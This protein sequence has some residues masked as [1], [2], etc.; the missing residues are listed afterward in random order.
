VLLYSS[1]GREVSV[2]TIG[3]GDILGEISILDGEPRS[4]SVVA[5]SDVVVVAKP[6]LAMVHAVRLAD[7][8]DLLVRRTAGV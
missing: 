4:A 2:N 7:E 3:P 8:Y 6:N 5:T 1:N